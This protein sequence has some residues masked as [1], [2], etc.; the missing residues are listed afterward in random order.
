MDA[1]LV[2][3]EYD[4]HDLGELITNAAAPFKSGAETKGIS[5]EI[6]LPASTLML[7]CDAHRM[8]I[9]LTNLLDNALK[10]T[11][12]GGV[13]TIAAEETSQEIKIRVADT[14]TGIRPD[15][16]LYVFDRFYRGRTQTGGGSGLG[17]AIAKSLVES[18]GGQLAAKSVF[19]EGSE[20]IIT[21]QK[22]K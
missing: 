17:L 12:P 19:G 15:E 22:S 9:V 14:G 4:N 20:F 18:Q 7:W 10:F 8:E 16:L 3:F 2:E 13:I 21:F 5:L 6:H 1:G 11:L